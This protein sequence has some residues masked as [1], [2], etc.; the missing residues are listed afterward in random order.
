MAD[1]KNYPPLD[2]TA[3]ASFSH[4]SAN[5]GS[6]EIQLAGNINASDHTSIRAGRVGHGRGQ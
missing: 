6:D 3:V 4:A 1:R 2:T 5:P